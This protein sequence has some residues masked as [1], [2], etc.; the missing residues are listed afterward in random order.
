MTQATFI[1]SLDCEG[2]WGMAD[3][4]N[5]HHDTVLTTSNL[6]EVY[7]RLLALFSKYQV[8]A[9]FAFVMALTLRPSEFRQFADLFSDVPVEGVNW[10][11]HFRR[12]S[13]LGMTDGW[14]APQAFDLVQHDGMHE[15]ASHG[16]THLPIALVSRIAAESEITSAG[17]VARSR[18]LA[19]RTFIFPR[20]LVAHLDILCNAGY[21]GFRDRSS[22]HA[23]A[24]ALDEYNPFARSHRIINGNGSLIVIPC[25]Y[26]LNYRS[27]LRWAVPPHITR[28]RWRNII[29]HAIVTNGV[30]HLWLH[31][32]NL[33]TAPKTIE[34]LDDILSYVDLQRNLGRIAILT[35]EQ[36]CRTHASHAAICPSIASGND[37]QI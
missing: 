3:R 28:L 14:F 30:A 12:Q 17:V 32:H 35:Q 22:R 23:Y 27:G 5:K 19:P 21:I 37:I 25:G 7:S 8:S 13:A 24:D 26:F 20:N 36:Y 1:V 11:Q 10:L 31:P 6:V 15:I 18:N 2:K 29:D 4:I 34:V 9:T 33:I 16:L